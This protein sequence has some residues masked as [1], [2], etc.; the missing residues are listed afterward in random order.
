MTQN[1]AKVR[2]VVQAFSIFF[3]IHDLRQTTEKSLETKSIKLIGAGAI[4]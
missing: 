4:R 1:I 3:T 2:H